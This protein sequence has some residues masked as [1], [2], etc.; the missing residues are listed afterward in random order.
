MDSVSLAMCA[1]TKSINARPDFS[2]SLVAS[3]ADPQTRARA[4]G[5]SMLDSFAKAVAQEVSS[6]LI[7]A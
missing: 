5:S 6:S 2:P 3:H 4:N 1:R 7:F